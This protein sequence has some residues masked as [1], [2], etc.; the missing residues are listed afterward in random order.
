MATASDIVA[1]DAINWRR[2]SRQLRANPLT[3]VGLAIIAVVMMLAALAPWITSYDPNAINPD[4]RLMPP[5]TDHWAGTDE[6]GR[7]IWTRILYGARASLGVGFGVVL[8][9]SVAGTLIGCFSGL[10]GGRI[11]N[12]IMR[13]MDV[14][15]ALPGLVIA[16]ALAAALGPSLINAMIAIGVLSIPLYARVARSQALAIRN[17]S[18]VRAAYAMGAGRWHML[19]RHIIP[20]ALTPMLVLATLDIGGSIIGTA[21]LSFIGLGA[22]PPL[23]EWGAMVNA[24]QAYILNE[25]WYAAFPGLA[26]LITV[27]AFN[28]VGDGVRDI[29]DP[30]GTVRK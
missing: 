6:V 18:F 16:M 12:L 2:L 1:M 9:G 23:A 29:L 24:G 20:N 19:R 7:D 15:M 27:L 28:L 5:S 14:V 22:Q 25:W 13:F 30:K 11:D 17:R 8:I 21:T 4:L 10:A 3:L 26:I